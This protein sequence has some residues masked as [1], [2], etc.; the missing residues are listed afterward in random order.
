MRRTER[1]IDKTNKNA[2]NNNN[3]NDNDTN[4]NVPNN[5]KIRFQERKENSK[6]IHYSC[7]KMTLNSLVIIHGG[8]VLAF[9]NRIQDIIFNMN[10]IGKLSY[11]LPNFHYARLIADNL[12]IPNLSQEVVIHSM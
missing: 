3:S 4:D 1:K 2:N 5:M 10:D 11:D 12:P 6:N 7:I 9:M 8:Y